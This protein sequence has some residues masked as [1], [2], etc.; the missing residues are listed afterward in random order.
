MISWKALAVARAFLA[1]SGVLLIASACT[2]QDLRTPS[3]DLHRVARVFD[4][5]TISLSGGEVV[6]YVGVDAPELN[7][8]SG[9]P[10]CY[11]P[12]AARRNR[13]LVGGHWVRLEADRTNRDVYGRLLRY[14]FVEDKFVNAELVREG[15]AYSYYR[16]PD[17]SRYE[18]LLQ[19]ELAA[20]AA[21]RG[22][23]GT[24]Q[25]NVDP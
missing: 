6:R 15:Y 13:E 18:E 7:P 5:D 8:E 24:C 14:V 2:D 22:L 3:G 10:E 21:G 4:G 17:V 16:P 19:L 12:E 9:E 23:W 1:V 25:K 20:E 11:A